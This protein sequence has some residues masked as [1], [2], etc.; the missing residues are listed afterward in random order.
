MSQSNITNTSIKKGLAGLYHI[1]TAI[2]MSQAELA[3]L[4]GLSLGHLSRVETGAHACSTDVCSR[5]ADS[6]GVTPNDLIFEPSKIRICKLRLQHL[7]KLVS[8]EQSKLE[9]LQQAC[10][11]SEA[12]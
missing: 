9:Q 5:L 2:D 4:A 11:Q 1:R 10:S 12:A 3:E 8:E 6:L 7:Q